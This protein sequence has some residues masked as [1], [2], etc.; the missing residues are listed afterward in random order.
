M[1]RAWPRT[2]GA[3]CRPKSSPRG[4]TASN[5]RPDRRAAMRRNIPSYNWRRRMSLGSLPCAFKCSWTASGNGQRRFGADAGLDAQRPGAANTA[6]ASRR[7]GRT[8]CCILRGSRGKASVPRC[9]PVRS[10]SD[11]QERRAAGE[12]GGL[13]GGITPRARPRGVGPSAR[14]AERTSPRRRRSQ[15]WPIQT[16]APGPTPPSG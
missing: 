10:A 5:S 1:S 9:T 14:G 7:R 11:E 13:H 2:A 6:R 8:P 12:I 4:S 3:C 15:V 16:A